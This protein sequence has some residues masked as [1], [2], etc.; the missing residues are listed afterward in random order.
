MDH[1]NISYVIWYWSHTTVSTAYCSVCWIMKCFCN[2]HCCWKVCLVVKGS[3]LV[4]FLENLILYKF[5]SA[6]GVSAKNAH[7]M[8]SI[9]S[10]IAANT[11]RSKCIPCRPKT[12]IG[13]VRKTT[14]R[15]ILEGPINLVVMTDIVMILD[16]LQH[17]KTQLAKITSKIKPVQVYQYN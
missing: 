3:S 5:A 16:C 17:V 12:E 2:I 13:S 11:C 15:D 9:E 4:K 7:T 8:S 6:L 14:N 10:T 1:N